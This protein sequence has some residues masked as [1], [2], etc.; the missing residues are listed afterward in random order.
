MAR[1]QVDK[2]LIEWKDTAAV[3]NGL[4]IVVRGEDNNCIINVYMGDVYKGGLSGD[5]NIMDIKEGIKEIIKPRY[6]EY[7]LTDRGFIAV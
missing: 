2:L 6:K 7:K 5:I 1:E 3:K 4:R